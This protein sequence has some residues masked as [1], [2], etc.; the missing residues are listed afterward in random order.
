MEKE[1]PKEERAQAVY[2]QV[3]L[4]LKSNQ[5]CSKQR[6]DF[7]Q[8]RATVVGRTGDPSFCDT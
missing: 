8:C 2:D 4:A 3:T 7:A 6:K 1:L 5:M